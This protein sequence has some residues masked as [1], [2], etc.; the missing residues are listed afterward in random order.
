MAEERIV[1]ISREL[2]YNRGEGPNWVPH[3]DRE[4]F[5]YPTKWPL[6]SDAAHVDWHKPIVHLRPKDGAGLTE[7]AVNAHKRVHYEAK[8]GFA[9]QPANSY[10][11]FNIAAA[12]GHTHGRTGENNRF[13]PEEINPEYGGGYAADLVSFDLK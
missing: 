7:F 1:G 6:P 8:I 11:L 4:A 9:N 2:A 3:E 13:I 5:N 10:R 12:N